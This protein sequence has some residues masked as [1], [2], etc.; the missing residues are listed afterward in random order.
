VLRECA[1]LD[2][3]IVFVGVL[4]KIEIWSKERWEN[5]N[6]FDDVD[7]IAEHMTQFG[8]SF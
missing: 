6:D 5:N 8:I 2:R 1:G 4:N 3:D 7:T